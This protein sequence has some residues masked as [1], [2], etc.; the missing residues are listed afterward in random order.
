MTTASTDLDKYQ[1]FHDLSTEVARLIA[2]LEV[3]LKQKMS[4]STSPTFSGATTTQKSKPLTYKIGQGLRSFWSGL[5]NKSESRLPSLKEYIAYNESINNLINIILEE[6]NLFEQYEDIADIINKFKNNFRNIIKKYADI[7]EPGHHAAQVQ[8]TKTH[9]T[10]YDVSKKD[11]E[12]NDEMKEYGLIA[13]RHIHRVQK[14]DYESEI[15]AG[16]FENGKIKPGAFADVLAWLID[17]NINISNESEIDDALKK[18]GY[19]A[20][21]FTSILNYLYPKKEDVKY[22]YKAIRDRKINIPN[23]IEGIKKEFSVLSKKE[24]EDVFDQLNQIGESGN[25]IDE[26]HDATNALSQEENLNPTDRVFYNIIK[27]YLVFDEENEL[28]PMFK[29]LHAIYNN[30]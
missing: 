11:T 29:E 18:Y 27:N 23:S 16:R 12:K 28:M 9:G 26:L 19:T 3:Q 30:K 21:D 15:S 4:K 2:D 13:R 1:L 8:S 20:S 14:P 24:M 25:I 10:P 7:L 5:S 22:L 6:R 17:S